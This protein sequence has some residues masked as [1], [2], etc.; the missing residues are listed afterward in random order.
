MD[1]LQGNKD[2]DRRNL[3]LC[4]DLARQY[5]H[6]ANELDVKH[7]QLGRIHSEFEQK[8][9]HTEVRLC[10]L[11]A[12]DSLLSFSSGLAGRKSNQEGIERHR[13]GVEFG[14]AKGEEWYEWFLNVCLSSPFSQMIVSS[15]F[16]GWSIKSQKRSPKS[17]R[18][19]LPNSRSITLDYSP[20]N[21]PG[22]SH[23]LDRR[24]LSGEGTLHRS[25]LDLKQRDGQW[26]S[27][28]HSITLSPI[29]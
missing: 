6:K 21:L 19:T 20:T 5:R 11:I 23:D 3:L 12:S 4:N 26:S 13:L 25:M 1:S 15:F 24:R 9:Q 29:T 27:S 18:F 16:L 8:V 14:S 17:R 7:L 22:K 10:A 28:S 2:K